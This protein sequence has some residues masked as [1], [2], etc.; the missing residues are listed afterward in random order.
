MSVEELWIGVEER[1]GSWVR[2]LCRLL[3]FGVHSKELTVPGLT[4]L[5]M[6]KS[7]LG[8]PFDPFVARDEL[9]SEVTLGADAFLGSLFLFSLLPFIVL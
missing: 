1:Q 4:G 7:L 6:A 2:P 3:L 9:V 8:T 5:T